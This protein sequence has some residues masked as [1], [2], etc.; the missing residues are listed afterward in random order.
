MA[1]HSMEEEIGA[2]WLSLES[3]GS[4]EVGL[5]FAA[6]TARK[7]RKPQPHSSPLEVPL[8]KANLLQFAFERW[9]VFLNKLGGMA[10]TGASITDESF[11]G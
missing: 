2:R 7:L 9:E 1:D 11:G 8:R 4:T 5:I 6:L 10:S 3:A